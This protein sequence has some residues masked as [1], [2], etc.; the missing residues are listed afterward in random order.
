MKIGRARLG[1][2]PTGESMGVFFESG[3]YRILDLLECET[4]LSDRRLQAHAA[5]HRTG[6]AASASRP[7]FR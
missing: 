7:R 5:V 2:G 4:G 6:L 1:L 3:F